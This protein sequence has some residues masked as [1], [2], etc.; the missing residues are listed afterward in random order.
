MASIDDL[1]T[2]GISLTEV[3]DSMDD[4]ETT[5][6]SITELI[7]FFGRPTGRF[8]HKATGLKSLN[9]LHGYRN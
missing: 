3:Q 5:V 1:E 2:A 8:S 4:V 6:M 9:I 7:I